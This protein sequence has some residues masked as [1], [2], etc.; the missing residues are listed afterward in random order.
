M[1]NSRYKYVYYVL[2]GWLKGPE[3]T[4]GTEATIKR[5]HQSQS[6]VTSKRVKDLFAI[7]AR[8]YQALF[9]QYG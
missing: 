5:L 7:A 4:L 8:A 6:V 3:A 2:K 1:L 9:T